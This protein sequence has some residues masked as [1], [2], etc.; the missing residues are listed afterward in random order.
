MTEP[1]AV[2]LGAGFSRR[3]GS[4]TRLTELRLGSVTQT[5]ADPTLDT[6]TQVFAAPRIVLRPEDTALKNLVATRYPRTTIV[7]APDAHLGMGHSLQAGLHELDW[8]GVFVGLFDMPYVRRESLE[9]LVAVAA[10]HNFNK[11]IRPEY[12]GT[13][14]DRPPWGHPIFIPQALFE[15]ARASS[16]DQGA[17]AL[18]QDHPSYIKKFPTDDIGVVRD[19]D[20]PDDLITG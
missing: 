13:V 18:L 1:G 11:I 12:L 9:Q 6:Y 19:I 7:E 20:T 14:K 16:G 8:S 17:R 2:L 4:A 10:E 15:A 5:V 3:F